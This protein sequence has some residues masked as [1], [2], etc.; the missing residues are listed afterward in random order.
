MREPPYSDDDLHALARGLRPPAYVYF[1]HE[2]EPSAPE[3]AQRLLQIVHS[4]E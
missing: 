3:Y 2:D 4:S 1:R